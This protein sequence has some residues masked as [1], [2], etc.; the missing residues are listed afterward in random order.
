MTQGQDTLDVAIAFGDLLAGHGG[1]AG[2]TQA[3]A[4]RG[5]AVL[6]GL[7]PA[8]DVV[9]AAGEHAQGV[10]RVRSAGGGRAH[11]V[12]PSCAVIR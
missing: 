11:R 2:G 9:A 1:R 6:A 8:L 4:E 10:V 5:A 7:T 12:S 3:R